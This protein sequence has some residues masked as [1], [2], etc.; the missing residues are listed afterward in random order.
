MSS[1]FESLGRA[2]TRKAGGQHRL[3]L[4]MALL[5]GLCQPGQAQEAQR[6]TPAAPP[7]VAVTLFQNV[8]IFDGKTGTLSA[9]KNVLVRGNRIE[10][11]TT[12]QITI[13]PTGRLVDGGGR[14]LMPG[15]I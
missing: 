5:V 3:L 13:D 15:L 4:L 10:R 9:P 2:T 8:R 1:V 12:D 6:A 11:V 7:A 14:S